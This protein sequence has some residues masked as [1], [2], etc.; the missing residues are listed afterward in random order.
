MLLSH[1]YFSVY[2]IQAKTYLLQLL[3]SAVLNHL[4][5]GTSLFL[6]LGLWFFTMFLQEITKHITKATGPG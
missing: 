6:F 1:Y 3:L 2:L 5:K 4:E